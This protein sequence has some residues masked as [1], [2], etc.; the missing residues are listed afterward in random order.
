[1]KTVRFYEHGGPEVLRVEDVAAPQPQAGE[2]LVA[3]EA[4]GVNFTDI[5]SRRGKALRVP[6]SFPYT[7]GVEVAGTVVG[8][9][10]GA[11]RFKKGD[12]V[13]ALIPH[14]GYSEMVVIPETAAVPIPAA[15]SA[16][17]A[18]ALPLQGL[19]AYHLLKTLG[20]LQPTEKVLVQAAAG[21]VGSLA[22]QL[23]KQTGAMVIAAAGT[24]A[25]LVRAAELG[26]DAGVLYDK[27]GWQDEVLRVTGGSGA[28]LLLDMRGGVGFSDNFAALAPFGR[29]VTF[30]AVAGERAVID[31]EKLTSRCHTVSGF[32]SAFVGRQPSL[33]GP[34]LKEL[35]QLV[36]EGRLKLDVNHRFPLAEAAEAHRQIEARVTTGKVLLA[37]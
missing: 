26:A 28:D 2:I 20:R 30:G 15:M 21:G 22:V 8:L 17:L 7:P 36:L 27:A 35:F 29:I 9:G 37:R 16:E 33:V 19:T 12:R 13:L 11:A 25:K 31:P 14:G 32:Y 18:V 4:A 1:M 23:A 10:E 34:P 24:E 3:V 5:S 6:V